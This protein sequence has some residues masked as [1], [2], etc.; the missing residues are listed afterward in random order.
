MQWLT[1]RKGMFCAFRPRLWAH[2]RQGVAPTIEHRKALSRFAFRTVVDV[3]ANRGQF[4]TFAREMFPGAAIFSFEP[5][6]GPAA[7]F[8]AVLGGD[9]R[10]HLARNAIGSRSGTAT[11]YVTTRDD[12]SSLLPPGKAQDEVFGVRAAGTQEI[13]IRRLGDCLTPDALAGPALLKIDV[14]GA[15]LEVLAGSADLIDRFDAIYVECSY[16]PMYDGQ[17]LV[18]DVARWMD[19]HGFRL[20]GVYNQYVDAGLGPV[21]ADFLFT[22]LATQSLPETTRS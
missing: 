12:S 3:G 22:R 17:P 14:Q 15:E 5:L 9:D 2:L 20:N 10:I 6:D 19:Q 11:I 16:L 8:E 4:A 7:T 21:Q 1:L 13:A 18:P